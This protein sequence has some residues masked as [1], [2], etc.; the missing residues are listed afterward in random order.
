M[1]NIYN[2]NDLRSEIEDE[3]S[4]RVLDLEDEIFVI[5]REEPIFD[6]Y[7]PIL[8]YEYADIPG[9]AFEKMTVNDVLN[10]MKEMSK[11]KSVK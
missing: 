9:E 2:Y 6:D 7:R 5:R 1:S 3:V 11:L 10:E 8:D 4:N